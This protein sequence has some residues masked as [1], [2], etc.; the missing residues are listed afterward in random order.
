MVMVMV[1][2]IKS[3]LCDGFFF[4]KKKKKVEGK[5]KLIRRGNE[6]ESEKEKEK[7]LF[8][9]KNYIRIGG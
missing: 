2:V 6:N 4:F 3:N 7:M 8:F 5:W 1:M 9:N